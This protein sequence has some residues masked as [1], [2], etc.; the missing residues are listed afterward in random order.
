MGV[1]P[2]MK[3]DEMTNPFDAK[4]KALLEAIHKACED[5][6]TA[7][8]QGI[9]VVRALLGVS[10]GAIR[11]SACC[12]EHM[13]QN[14]LSLAQDF[15]RAG[16]AA[17]PPNSHVAP[18]QF[19]PDTHETATLRP[20][21]GQTRLE[22]TEEEIVTTNDDGLVAFVGR[23]FGPD[24]YRPMFMACVDR[25]VFERL[26]RAGDSITVEV[27]V[28]DKPLILQ[29]WGTE[30]RAQAVELIKARGM[31]EEQVEAADQSIRATRQ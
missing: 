26:V 18:D 21:G 17:P 2:A 20:L 19:G 7:G 15:V 9:D 23:G 12:P 3:R 11:N 8:G 29:L 6:I 30:T 5:Y 28:A 24:G 16:M 1:L 14:L 13:Q 31:T 10:A 25:A 27:S 22:R 4:T